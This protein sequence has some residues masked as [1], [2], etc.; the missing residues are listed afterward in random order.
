MQVCVAPGCLP[1]RL[2]SKASE[3]FSTEHLSLPP[4][5]PDA[6]ARP[7]P[8]QTDARSSPSYMQLPSWS[9]RARIERREGE[10]L[11]MRGVWGREELEGKSMLRG[12]YRGVHTFGGLLWRA[13]RL[14]LQL[15]V[16]FHR[17]AKSERRP[18]PEAGERTARTPAALTE[19]KPLG[20]PHITGTRNM[21]MRLR[22]AVGN[23]QES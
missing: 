17:K 23:S 8:V 10:P 7:Q 20:L 15:G 2:L 18:K 16:G 13:L 11:G 12:H 5:S 21:Q 3:A 6:C 9:Q 22:T 19:F 4:I 14:C 1:T